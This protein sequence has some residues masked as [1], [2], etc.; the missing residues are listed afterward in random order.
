MT[1]EPKYKEI[2]ER[3]RRGYLELGYNRRQFCRAVEIDYTAC[4]NWE[5]GLKMPSGDSLLRISKVL[6]KT[7]D[8]IV[9]G[10][11][12]PV[13]N[14]PMPGYMKIADQAFE[15][16]LRVDASLAKQFSKEELAEIREIRFRAGAPSSPGFYR[17]IALA[18]LEHRRGVDL[19]QALDA[20]DVT[21]KHKAGESLTL[22]AAPRQT[23]RR[24]R[25]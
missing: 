5:K 2:G 14:S 12:E 1:T 4:I 3:I 13:R 25:A 21:P 9:S 8:F 17:Y 11:P 6:H 7:V 20:E 22:S 15:E 10:G 19:A 16:F 18:K 24:K 23:K